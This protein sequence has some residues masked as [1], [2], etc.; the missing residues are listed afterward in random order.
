MWFDTKLGEPIKNP[1]RPNQE[2][3]SFYKEG[4]YDFFV[5]LE[6]EFKCASVCKPPLFYITYDISEGKP[7]QGCIIPV[8]DSWL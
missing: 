5:G 1:N 2:I 7:D 8:Q 4:G 3:N 6:A